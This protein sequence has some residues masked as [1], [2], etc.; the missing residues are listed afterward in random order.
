MLELKAK[1]EAEAN[2]PSKLNSANTNKAHP[3][4]TLSSSRPPE[5]GFTDLHNQFNRKKTLLNK[6]S[7][8]VENLDQFRTQDPLRKRSM[9]QGIATSTH[10]VPVENKIKE[11]AQ[12]EEQD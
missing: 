11:L 12:E 7:Y 8:S 3:R 10:K 5:F 6:K 4:K 2:S 9:N 1:E